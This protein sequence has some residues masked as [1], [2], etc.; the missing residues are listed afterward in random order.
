MSRIKELEIRID[1]LEALVTVGEKIEVIENT[2]TVE[3]DQTKVEVICF[4][5][6]LEENEIDW[7]LFLGNCRLENQR[8]ESLEMCYQYIEDLKKHSPE[9][10]FQFSF[11][12]RLSLIKD[13]DL[14]EIDYQW[15]I[16][17][18]ENSH[19]EIIWE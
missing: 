10:W 15:R 1:K 18:L 11:H 4:K 17:V 12:W 16:I 5:E 6:F 14:E 3:I 7:I 19:A 9:N 13:K 8:W 2:A